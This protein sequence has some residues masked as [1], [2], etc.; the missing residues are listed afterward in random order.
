M[1]IAA[2]L[3]S[4]FH[5]A[6]FSTRL[7]DGVYLKQPNEMRLSNPLVPKHKVCDRE[8]REAKAQILRHSA[9]SVFAAVRSKHE[10]GGE[11]THIS[12]LRRSGFQTDH[13]LP[14]V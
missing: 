4:R 5:R 9:G 1:D 11:L 10:K 8:V 6:F 3:H 13:D 2:V 7:S 12:I 14:G